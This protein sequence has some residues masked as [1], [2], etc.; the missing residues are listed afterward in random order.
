[1]KSFLMLT[2]AV[3]FLK[4]FKIPY[5]EQL[6]RVEKQSQKRSISEEIVPTYF[7]DGDRI[8]FLLPTLKNDTIKA[9]ADTGGGWSMMY[10]WAIERQELKE[11][12]LTDSTSGRSFLF[13]EKVFKHS[14]YHPLL[15]EQDKKLS[16]KP[17]FI[18]PPK[19]MVLS[20]GIE[21]LQE[22]A[23][24]GQYFFIKH[25]WKFDY[26]NQ[27][28]TILKNPALDIN[29]SNTHEI[30]FK[31]DANG[32]KLFGHA[33]LNI[34][35]AGDTIPVLFDTGAMF[36]LSK[37]AQQTLGRKKRIGGS[38]IASSIVSKWKK[39]HPDWEVITGGDQVIVNG[40]IHSADMIKV[41]EI[42]IGDVHIGPVWFSE[43]PD[44]VWSK[45]MIKTMNTAVQG[46]LGGS[47]LKYVSVTIDY[48]N[49]LINVK[50]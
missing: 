45:G 24:L 42:Q 17:F 6:E 47:A 25:S 29:H 8:Y 19:Q 22:D 48:P 15:T 46:A 49:E 44:I 32:N 16:K 11:Q 23:F 5:Q 41:P 26:K 36:H 40:T 35:I 18:V 50:K 20:K 10:P 39:D 3:I 2:T 21:L 37:T 4:L 34:G 14:I 31:K 1:M 12:L 43:R 9:Y 33:S 38:F 30:G 28:V 27:T 13:A 7:D